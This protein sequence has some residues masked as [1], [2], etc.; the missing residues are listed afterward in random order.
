MSKDLI[1]TGKFLLV[2]LVFVLGFVSAQYRIFPANIITPITSAYVGYLNA[3]FNVEKINHDWRWYED[4]DLPKGMAYNNFEK[5]QK[6]YIV[7]TST[8]DTKAYVLDDKGK[9]LFT[10]HLDVE[11]LWPNQ[12]HVQAVRKVPFENFTLRDFHVFPDGRIVVIVS[13]YGTT[14]WGAGIVMMDKDSNV[15][16][17][18]QGNY[19][20]DLHVNEAGEIFALRHEITMQSDLGQFDEHVMFNAPYLQDL[21]VKINQQGEVLEQYAVVDMLRRSKFKNI[22]HHTNDDGK[23]DYT[24]T[25]SIEFIEADINTAPYMAAGDILALI[26]NID[27]LVVIDGTSKKVK[28]ASRVPVRMPHDIDILK[29]GN[30]LLYDNQ[31]HLGDEGYSRVVEFNPN[32]FAVEWSYVGSKFRPFESEFWGFQQ[33]LENGNTLTT[34]PNKGRLIE[35]TPEGE[36]V[37]EYFVPHRKVENGVSYNPVLTSAEKIAPSYFSFINRPEI[38]EAQ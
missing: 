1:F 26:R 17:A 7:Y 18:L 22:L 19:Y 36:I 14:P 4:E 32:N 23:G 30:I 6:D 11:A 5:T 24:H 9:E 34:V 8:A 35:V 27:V 3:Y 38:Q 37:M 33:R 20:N 13:L 10:W 15:L 12:E 16:W 21:V 29:N 31:G 25:N 28:W 2:L